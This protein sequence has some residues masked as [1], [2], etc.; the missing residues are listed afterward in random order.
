MYHVLQKPGMLTVPENGETADSYLFIYC[1]IYAALHVSD[2]Y[3]YL[4][5]NNNCKVTHC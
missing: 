2:M 1:R 3:I 5:A 4:I